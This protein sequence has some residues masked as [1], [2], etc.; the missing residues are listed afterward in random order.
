[1]DHALVKLGKPALPLVVAAFRD[2]A[3]SVSLRAEAARILSRVEKSRSIFAIVEVLAKAVESNPSPLGARLVEVLGDLRDPHPLPTLQNALRH[4][5]PTVRFAAAIALGKIG[6]PTVFL[7][8]IAALND[9]DRVVLA[10]ANRS[11]MKL[12]GTDQGF[13]TDLSDSDR[14]AMINRW[15]IWWLQNKDVY[16]PPPDP[17]LL[18]IWDHA[19]E[20]LA[21]AILGK[22]IPGM[23]QP[24]IFPGYPFAGNEPVLV[25]TAHLPEG[26]LPVVE[27]RRV[28]VKAEK[29]LAPVPKEGYWRFEPLKSDGATAELTLSHVLPDGETASAVV[30][31]RRD[32]GDWTFES[33]NV[34][35][36]GTVSQAGG[37]KSALTDQPSPDAVR[38]G[39]KAT[40]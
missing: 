8:L 20:I 31:Y 12:S 35:P 36:N 10:A 9:P 39:Q 25:S 26:T 11:L 16:K 7:P 22:A 6:D 27:G 32:E 33:V 15:N 28:I 5:D 30:Q 37:T 1:L 2:P 14:L 40:P 21:W 17:V 3:R 13:S 29:D 23:T 4:D 38:D 24:A 18:E 19:D 34:K